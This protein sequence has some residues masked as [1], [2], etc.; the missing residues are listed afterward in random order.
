[1]IETVFALY[2]LCLATPN[3]MCEEGSKFD[4]MAHC[5]SARA[6]YDRPTECREEPFDGEPR[7]VGE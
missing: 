4:T 2:V 5:Q 7:D 6:F 3:T 1:M